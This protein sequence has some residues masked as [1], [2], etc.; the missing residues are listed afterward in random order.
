MKKITILYI[1]L[2]L[3]ASTVIFSQSLT[4]LYAAVRDSDL[5][6]KIL[7]LELENRKIQVETGNLSPGLSLSAG[8]AWTYE[9]DI[10]EFTPELTVGYTVLR[11]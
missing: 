8:A 11:L 3:S 4:D 2:I 5:Q 1:I 7:T 9:S 6:Y 10:S